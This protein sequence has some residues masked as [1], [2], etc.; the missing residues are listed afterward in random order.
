MSFLS[1][2][3]NGFDGTMFLLC[4]ANTSTR[5]RMQLPSSISL[6]SAVG[7]STGRLFAGMQNGKNGVLRC[8]CFPFRQ[9]PKRTGRRDESTPSIKPWTLLR[10][11]WKLACSPG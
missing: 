10:P 9:S 4:L 8:D 7:S 11:N 1:V 5:F 2:A 6:A 3:R